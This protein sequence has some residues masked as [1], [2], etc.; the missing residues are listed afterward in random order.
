MTKD[1]V[2]ELFKY[3]ARV[4]GSKGY[5]VKQHGEPLEHV[6]W[7]CD[8]GCAFVDEDKVDKAMRWLGFVQGALWS[9]GIYRIEDLVLHSKYGV[10]GK[11]HYVALDTNVLGVVLYFD[12]G[13]MDEGE[14]QCMKEAYERRLGD[15]ERAEKEVPPASSGCDWWK[16]Q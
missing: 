8:Q 15:L 2:K 12:P 4:L 5:V 3:Y 16:E 14:I 1:R 7:C 11:P 6:L 9:G 13:D 10:L